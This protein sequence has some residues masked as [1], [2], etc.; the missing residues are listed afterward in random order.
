MKRN[1]TF[2]PTR[3]LLLF[4]W[5]CSAVVMAQNISGK[6]TDENGQALPGV[7]VTEKALIKEL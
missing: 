3:W 7:S 5:L 1:S 2:Q 6:V 4:F